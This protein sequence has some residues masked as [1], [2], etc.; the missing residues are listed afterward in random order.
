MNK[1]ETLVW[2]TLKQIPDPELNV[3]LVDLGLIYKVSEK[4]GN[5]KI[6]M[7][8]T[9]VGCPLYGI[10]QKDIQNKVKEIEG[11]KQVNISLT[12][13]P[14]WTMERISSEAKEQLG[15]E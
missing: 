4:N 10:M 15:I 14:P 9:T 12:F 11:V 3:S 8:L 5:V 13:D 1:I 6:T 7:T 2:Q